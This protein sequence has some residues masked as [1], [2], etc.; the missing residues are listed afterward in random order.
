[1]KRDVRGL[2]RH[3]GAA[4]DCDAD[5]SLRECGRVVDA[6][7]DHRDVPAG[8]LECLHRLNLSLGM[9]SATTVVTPPAAR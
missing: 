2:H 1:M 3:V 7:P 4:P 9:T 5:V 6:V 8:L